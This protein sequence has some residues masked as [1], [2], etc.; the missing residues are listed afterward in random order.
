MAIKTEN[1]KFPLLALRD[2][3][4]LPQVITHFDAARKPSVAAIE[5]AD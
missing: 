4:I 3:V 5:R 2:M 1:G